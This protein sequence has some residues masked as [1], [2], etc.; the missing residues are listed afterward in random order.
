MD[1]QKIE[2]AI[3][4]NAVDILSV[5]CSGNR[6]KIIDLLTGYLW[7]EE[8][9]SGIKESTGKFEIVLTKNCKGCSYQRAREEPFYTCFHPEY[10]GPTMMSK[11]KIPSC[12]P[13]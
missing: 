3:I 12:C 4:S 5:Q 6:D 2:Y 13:L 10:K 1:K 7:D 8:E 9:A 11:A